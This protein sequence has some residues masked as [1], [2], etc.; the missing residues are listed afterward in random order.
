MGQRRGTEVNYEKKKKTELR[1]N[2]NLKILSLG[3]V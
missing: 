3:A 2:K 1:E